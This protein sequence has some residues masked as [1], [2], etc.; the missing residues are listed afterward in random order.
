VPDRQSVRLKYIFPGKKSYRNYYKTI[1]F[2]SFEL[3][4]CT[5]TK[6]NKGVI[7][8]F[9]GVLKRNNTFFLCPFL[10]ILIDFL[11]YLL[12]AYL[13]YLFASDTKAI[14]CWRWIKY[15]FTG[16][17]DMSNIAFPII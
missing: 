8:T 6:A 11:F 1:A 13:I 9:W 7:P 3:Y 14:P 16:F 5:C 2:N 17:C 10:S 12:F 4:L 15:L